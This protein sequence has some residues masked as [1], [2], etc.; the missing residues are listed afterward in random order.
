MLHLEHIS[1]DTTL[2]L[3]NWGVTGMHTCTHMYV[4]IQMHARTHQPT[5][6]KEGAKGQACSS[7]M[8]P[9]VGRMPYS[10]Q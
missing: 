8:R 5:V 10:P 7:E 4:R 2:H 3:I 6:S 9:Q 1:R